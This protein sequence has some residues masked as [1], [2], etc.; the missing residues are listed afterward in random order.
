MFVLEGVSSVPGR[1]SG[2]ARVPL[3]GPC[4]EGHFP[5]NPIL[6]GVLQI[7]I[8]RAA[9]SAHLG[10]RAEVVAIDS[11]RLRAPVRPGDALRVDLE[12]P[13]AHGPVARVRVDSGAREPLAVAFRLSLDSGG[14]GARVCHGRLR[15]RLP[16]VA[17]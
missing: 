9:V 8:V 7:E 11:M 3:S 1:W 17:P 16:E 4:F 12:I 13:D 14:D 2:L 5:G 6:P 10:V 15:A